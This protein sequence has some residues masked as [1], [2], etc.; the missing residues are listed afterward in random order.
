MQLSKSGSLP[1]VRLYAYRLMPSRDSPSPRQ[2][3]PRSFI[4]TGAHIVQRETPLALYKGLGAVL[5]GI[6]PKMAI[7][8]ASFETYK[9]WMAHKETGV[10]SVGGIFFG[11]FPCPLVLL[12]IKGLGFSRSWAWSGCHRGSNGRYSDGGRKDSASGAIPFSC[13]SS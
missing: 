9:G 7:R 3:K 13:R 8:F 4:A 1:G 10:T 2:T 12:Y 5:A 11:S 6:V